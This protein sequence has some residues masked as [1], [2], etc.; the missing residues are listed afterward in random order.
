MDFLG[1]D[2]TP[3][4]VLVWFVAFFATGLVSGGTGALLASLA[5]RR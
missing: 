2:F 5:R 1:F 4:G 3:S